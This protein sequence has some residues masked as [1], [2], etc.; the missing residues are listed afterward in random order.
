MPF[1]GF[2]PAE[3]GFVVLE[4]QRPAKPENAPAIGFS[5][6]L[7]GFVQRCWDGN[8]EQ[9]PKV[10]EVVEH[11]EKAVADWDGLM[12]PDTRAEDVVPDST[13]DSVYREFEM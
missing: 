12:P 10:T 5:D 8:K 13:S 2:R 9:R 7:W 4:G 11:L 3:L 6:L 1:S